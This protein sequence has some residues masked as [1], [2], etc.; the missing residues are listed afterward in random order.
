MRFYTQ[1]CLITNQKSKFYIVFLVALKNRV[2]AGGNGKWNLFIF[3][4]GQGL[5]SDIGHAQQGQS[6]QFSAVNGA[7]I[8]VCHGH[9]SGLKYNIVIS[10]NLLILPSFQVSHLLNRND[11]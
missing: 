2:R 11:F 5:D 8:I 6:Y 1:I 3:T 9:P 7:Q 4:T 10:D